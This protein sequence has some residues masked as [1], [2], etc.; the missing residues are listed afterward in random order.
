MTA[1]ESGLA[2]VPLAAPMLAIALA[3]AASAAT[4]A[5]AQPSGG[6]PPSTDR[7]QRLVPDLAIEEPEP[8][9]VDGLF[10][11]RVGGSYVYITGDGRHAFTGDLLDL[12][13][14]RNL[15]E[16]RRNGDRLS[17]LDGFPAEA[18]LVLPAMGEERHRIHVFTDST[19]PYCQK[20]HEEVPALRKAG[21][22]VAYIP[23]PRGGPRGPGYRELQSVWCADDPA[24]AFDIAAGTDDG[25]LVATNPDCDAARSVDAGFDL[26]AKLGVQ[27]TPTIVLPSGAALPGYIESAKLLQRLRLD[28]VASAPGSEATP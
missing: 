28:D 10:E 11:V 21:V 18:L 1:N 23:F 7:L 27:G 15:T 20:L 26:G 12:T 8:T 25:E 5:P 22:T 14:G 2:P 9:A 19:C 24:A 3:L 6:T 16:A 17:A 13:T 4:A